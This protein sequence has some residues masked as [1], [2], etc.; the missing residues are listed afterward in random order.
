MHYN[1]L[2]E[3]PRFPR[4]HTHTL[5]SSKSPFTWQ[6]I[7]KAHSLENISTP[8]S[9]LWRCLYYQSLFVLVLF[10]V[11]ILTAHSLPLLKASCSAQLLSHDTKENISKELILCHTLKHKVSHSQIIRYLRT[12]VW[13]KPLRHLTRAF[14]GA[15][16]RRVIVF[17]L[18]L[19]HEERKD[20]RG[21]KSFPLWDC[22][23]FLAVPWCA[24]QY[25][26]QNNT[27]QDVIYL[28]IGFWEGSFVIFFKVRF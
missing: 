5:C 2:R 24:W 12:P 22:K 7:S 13:K 15:A 18:L 27:M 4:P 26:L 9:L 8:Y 23:I 11:R 19:H 3:T 16:M 14:I 1:C 28:F 10:L 17:A 20:R 25:P 6:C 21:L